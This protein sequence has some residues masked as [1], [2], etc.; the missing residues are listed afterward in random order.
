[1][2]KAHQFAREVAIRRS[3]DLKKFVTE[4]LNPISKMSEIDFQKLFPDRT[5]TS[6]LTTVTAQ[7]SEAVKRRNFVASVAFALGLLFLLVFV[8]LNL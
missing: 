7:D 6:F 5:F 4:T 2:Q 8:G 3:D 1:M